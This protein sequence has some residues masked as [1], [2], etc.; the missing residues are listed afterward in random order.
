MSFHRSDSQH[1]LHPSLEGNKLELDLRR[2]RPDEMRTGPKKQQ[3]PPS[4]DSAYAKPYQEAHRTRL[5]DPGDRITPRSR[6]PMLQ[7]TLHCL[8]PAAANKRAVASIET[9]LKTLPPTPRPSRSSARR[10]NPF[11]LPQRNPSSG[12][13][14]G[15]RKS[16]KVR[17]GQVRSV[18]SPN[19]SPTEDCLV[20]VSGLQRRADQRPPNDTP[21]SLANTRELPHSG[22][23]TSLT[24]RRYS[25][26]QRHLSDPEDLSTGSQLGATSVSLHL[27][28][29][30]Q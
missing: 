16:S 22:K 2:R 28:H 19:W 9:V 27:A 18:E 11:E 30:G 6:V 13:D 5:Q 24:S 4:L 14:V 20:V 7:S 8:S 21:L 17:S 25:L 15:G 23:Q 29:S 1:G 10:L 12:R 26:K 3:D